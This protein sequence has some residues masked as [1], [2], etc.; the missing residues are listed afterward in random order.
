MT[1]NIWLSVGLKDTNL[2]SALGF[3]GVGGVEI[4]GVDVE[5][6]EEY[7]S[8]SSFRTRP[9]LPVPT[10]SVMSIPSSL[11]LCR[12]PGVVTPR[13]V[14]FHWLCGTGGRED[15]DPIAL[16]SKLSDSSVPILFWISSVAS[17]TSFAS[18]AIGVLASSA[19]TSPSTSISTRG[20]LSQSSSIA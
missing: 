15:T 9:F 18:S 14:S 19:A 1:L 16:T 6:E 8:I 17:F 11:S 7:L 2:S 4:T 12:T 10:T 5:R 13:P 3:K 20:C